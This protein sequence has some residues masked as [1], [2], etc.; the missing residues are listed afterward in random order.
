VNSE[1]KRKVKIK[2]MINIKGKYKLQ[3]EGKRWKEGDE[4]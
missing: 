2:E 4:E 3:G 1:K